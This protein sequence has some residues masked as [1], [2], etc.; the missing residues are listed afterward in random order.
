MCNLYSMTRS[1]DEV[2]WL[3]VA[4][5]GAGMFAPQDATFPGATRPVVRLAE[6]GEREL[7]SMR[8]LSF[9]CRSGKA[10]RRVTNVRDDLLE[11]SAGTSPKYAPSLV[12]VGKRRRSPVA[13]RMV[14][15]ATILMP[16]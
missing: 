10:P 12:G 4:D 13:E 9:C 16:A 15:A 3:G 1:R 8:W 2:R 5:N 14:E 7:L 6:D 11:C